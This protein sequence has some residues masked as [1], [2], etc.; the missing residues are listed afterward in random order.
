[1]VCTFGAYKSFRVVLVNTARRDGVFL[2][3]V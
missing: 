3:V 1:L 2:F